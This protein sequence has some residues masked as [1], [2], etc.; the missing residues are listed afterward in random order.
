M[1]QAKPSTNHGQS[2]KWRKDNKKNMYYKLQLL[3]HVKMH[4][5][6]NNKKGQGEVQLCRK[7][8]IGGKWPVTKVF[9]IY[10]YI[11]MYTNEKND[12]LPSHRN[13]AV[14]AYN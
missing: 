12:D 9:I 10:I 14:I 13:K 6:N 2:N 1:K 8:V 4:N 11:Y 7:Y 5:N 3:L